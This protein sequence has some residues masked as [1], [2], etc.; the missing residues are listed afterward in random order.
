M[1]LKTCQ[2]RAEAFAGWWFAMP[3]W[4]EPMRLRDDSNQ[5]DIWNSLPDWL[6]HSRP[7]I[8]REIGVIRDWMAAGARHLH[9]YRWLLEFNGLNEPLQS[10]S[11][12]DG[13]S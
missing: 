3:D 11:R 7:L 9:V 5:E 1:D 6:E 4:L 2:A 10:R 13:V 12:V 8:V